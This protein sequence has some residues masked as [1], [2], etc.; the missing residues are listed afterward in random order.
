[1]NQYFNTTSFFY[2]RYVN[3]FMTEDAFMIGTTAKSDIFCI[4]RSPLFDF[5]LCAS[6]WKWM[7]LCARLFWN[8][9]LTD[10][11][12]KW[13]EGNRNLIWLYAFGSSKKN[14]K[15]KSK[16]QFGMNYVF[17]RITKNKFLE[18]MKLTKKETLF[19]STI[20]CI[21]NCFNDSLR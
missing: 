6:K 14:E 7:D 10:G 20:F 11:H 19:L 18:N 15:M 1:M 16:F 5:W 9:S 13:D 4:R 17:A 3:S 2:I 8:L 12:Q 21:Y